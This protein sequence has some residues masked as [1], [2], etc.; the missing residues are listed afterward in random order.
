MKKILAALLAVMLMLSF[1]ACTASN[2]SKDTA[3]SDKPA[4][5][6]SEKPAEDASEQ[7]SD[8]TAEDLSWKNIEDK[9]SFTLGFDEAFPPMGF[10]DDTGEHVGFDIDMAKEVAKILGV[11][12]KLQPVDWDSKIMELNNGNIDLIWNGLSITEE[13][14]KDMLFSN[15]YMSNRQVVVVSA[16]SGIKTIADLAGKT[17][18]A[19]V[20]SA[21]LE[22]IQGQPDVMDT[23]GELIESADY[24]TAFMELK[25][26]TVDAVA[27]DEIYGRYQI[28]QDKNPDFFAVLE[29][30]FG[31]ETYGVGFRLGDTAFR[32]KVQEAFNTLVE[33]GTAAEISKKWFNEDIV[34]S[35]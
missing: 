19:Q 20:D 21:A 22:A 15:P 12:L 10:K 31:E 3:A 17:V 5:Q 29:D 28:A 13:N 7:P 6:A 9:G 8:D 11:E 33:N 16:E 2:D 18:A 25:Q 35:E 30:N 32:D 23:F 4:E 34:I 14:K 26:G 1:A 24:V 27:V